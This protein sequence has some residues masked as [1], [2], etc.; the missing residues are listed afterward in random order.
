MS[1]II[2]LCVGK[3]K[4]KWWA[5]AQEEYAKRLAPVMRV[6]IIEVAPEPTSATLSPEQ[7]M[8]AEGERL[9]KRIDDDAFV[10]ALER[11][12]RELSSSEL[13]DKLLEPMS[14]GRQV[15]FVIGGSEGLA[16]AV[17]KR[18]DYKWSLSQLTFVHEMARVIVL[19]QIYRATMIRAGR[20]Y[21]K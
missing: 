10:V 15:V 19:E 6:E 2:L 1:K 21:H 5:A 12:G 20:K 18:A 16:E 17:L 8:R 14:R 3:L 7:S 11:T 9:M 13:A 4:E